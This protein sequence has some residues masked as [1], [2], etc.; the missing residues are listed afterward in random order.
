MI[1]FIK[2]FI[3]VFITFLVG[4]DKGVGIL[5][6]KSTFEIN[7]EYPSVNYNNRIRQIILHHTV[8]NFEESLK[9]L[10]GQ[11]SIQVSSHYLINDHPNEEYPNYIYNLVRDEKRSWHAG[12]SQWGYENDINNSSIGIEIVN[13]DGNVHAYPGKQIEAVIF[14]LKELIKRHEI[15]PVNVIGQ[16]DIA[17]GRKIDPGILFPWKLLYDKGIGAWYEPEELKAMQASITQLP[18]IAQIKEDLHK[19]GYAW[20]MESG[21]AQQYEQAV[22]AFKRHFNPGNLNKEMSLMDYQILKVLLKK[23]R[24]K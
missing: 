24:S 9:I 1:I 20:D 12:I 16:S 11:K 6:A 2:L 10:D 4:C 22:M 23:Y 8:S 14:L 15:E 17:P 21:D 18:P 19:Y 13:A 5:K 7:Y 3:L